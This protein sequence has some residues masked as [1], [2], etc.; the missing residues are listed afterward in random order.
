[1]LYFRLTRSAG[2]DASH[3]PA[4]AA[5]VTVLL[6]LQELE[7]RPVHFD[8]ELP[9]GEIEFD[10]KIKQV[11]PLRAKG[12]AKLLNN[13]LGEIRVKGH[14]HVQMEAPCDRCLETASL[15]LERPF[16]LLYYPADELELSGADEIEKEASEVA[17]YEGGR[18]ELNDVLRE[19]VLLELPMQVV[20]SEACKGI[21]PKCGQNRNTHNCGCTAGAADD[22]WTKLRA[23]RTELSPGH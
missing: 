22:R 6:S 12:M 2:I 7:L 17:Y 13:S 3:T 18:L 14:L 4:F 16:D 8:L 20:C 1:M 19:V 11:T 9:V 21:C 15:P 23:L 10:K 5:G